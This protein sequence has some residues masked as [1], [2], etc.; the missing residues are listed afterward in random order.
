MFLRMPLDRA[1]RGTCSFLVI[2]FLGRIRIL[3]HIAIDPDETRKRNDSRRVLN[4]KV[5]FIP[6]Q[7]VR[8]PVVRCCKT[9]G[10][11]P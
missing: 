4:S 8:M 6:V 11:K 10:E 2:G 5:C 1:Q 7:G 3:G 9:W